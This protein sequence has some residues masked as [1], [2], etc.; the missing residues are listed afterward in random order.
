MLNRN[1][2]EL[3]KNDEISLTN[4]IIVILSSNNSCQLYYFE[5][6]NY[7]FIHLCNQ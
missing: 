5:M 2:L 6:F 4:L 7:I 3:D 1:M